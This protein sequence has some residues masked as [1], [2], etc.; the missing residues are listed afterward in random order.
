M[1]LVARRLTGGGEVVARGGGA[2]ILRDEL[3]VVDGYESGLFVE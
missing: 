2:E 1:R 3:S